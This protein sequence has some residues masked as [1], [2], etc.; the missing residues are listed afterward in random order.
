MSWFSRY[1]TS[2]VGGKHLVGLTGLF[3]VL[4][5]LQH[6]IGNLL[7]FAGPDALNGYAVGLKSLGH[8][9]VVWLARGGL[10]ALALAH[11]VRSLM[12]AA[13]NRRAR[14]TAYVK[15]KPVR[16]KFYQRWMATTGTLI[17]VFVVYHL[18]HFTF[19]LTNPDHFH[20]LDAE[21]RHDVYRMVILGF[22]QPVIAVSYIVA[23][24]LLCMHLAHGASSFFQSLGWKHPKYDGVIEKVGPIVALVVFVGNVS[25]PVAVLA[26]VIGGG[27]S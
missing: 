4:F 11:V 2:S 16:S 13:A 26:G 25:M 20:A 9:V 21:G 27:V 24:L 17:L 18:L 19:G 3:L 23:M 10:L 22:Q 6:M 7:V 5:V 14:P 15:Y 1:L 12:L 8:G